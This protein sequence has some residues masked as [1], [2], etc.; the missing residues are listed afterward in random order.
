MAEIGPK[1]GTLRTRTWARF[2]VNN[3]YLIQYFEQ[4]LRHDADVAAISFLRFFLAYSSKRTLS[5]W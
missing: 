5:V 4:Y 1:S 3:M 2:L